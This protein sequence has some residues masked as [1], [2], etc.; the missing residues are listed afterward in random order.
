M[1][2]RS[3]MR[4]LGLGS[5]AAAAVAVL[6]DATPRWRMGRFTPSDTGIGTIQQDHLA[7]TTCMSSMTF[8]HSD[9]PRGVFDYDNFVWRPRR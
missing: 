8:D 1:D 3:F 6:P 2:R 5:A 4:L 7:V 9:S